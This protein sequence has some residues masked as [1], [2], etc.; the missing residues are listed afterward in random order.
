MQKSLPPNKDSLF[1]VGSSG[2]IIGFIITTVVTALGLTMSIPSPPS[3]NVG[4]LPPTL[5]FLFLFRFL[6]SFG[7]IPQPTDAK[8]LL[9]VHPVAL[10]GW[11][12]MVIT[13]LNLLPAAML[14]GGHVARSIVG[15]RI[16]SVLTFL[17]ILLLVLEGFWPMA[18]FVLFM[19]M[20]RHPGPLD[21]VSSLSTNRKLL[22]IFLIVIFVLCSFP[23]ST[24]F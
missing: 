8:P 9:L 20:Y 17:S 10:A 23:L 3:E 18:V 6:D 4:S 22:T 14:D 1:D 15:E 11:V 19:S 13:M 21:D 24:I 7:F 12:G 5:L 16:R 2:P